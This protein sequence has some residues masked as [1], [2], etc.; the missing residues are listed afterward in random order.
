MNTKKILDSVSAPQASLVFTKA[1]GGPPGTIFMRND[2]APGDLS[3]GDL[4]T[5]QISHDDGISW[6]DMVKDGILVQLSSTNNHESVYGP[7]VYR[8]NLSAVTGPV[9]AY[10]NRG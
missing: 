6:V 4:A 3:A 1:R 5:V 2:A 9:S 8:L 7:G 10:Y